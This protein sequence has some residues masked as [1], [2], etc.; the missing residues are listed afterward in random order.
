LGNNHNRK[1]AMY[2]PTIADIRVNNFKDGKT[3]TEIDRATTTWSS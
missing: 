3:L 2:D 1:L